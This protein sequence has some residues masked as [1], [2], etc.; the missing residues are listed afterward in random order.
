MTSA[1]RAGSSNVKK[2]G[3]EV[4]EAVEAQMTKEEKKAEIQRGE[5]MVHHRTLYL[6]FWCTRLMNRGSRVPR[7]E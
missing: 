7:E 3:L 4:F 2:G 1:A 6:W 5:S